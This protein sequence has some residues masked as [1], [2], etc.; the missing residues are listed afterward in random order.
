MKK[1]IIKCI[2]P[3]NGDGEKDSIDIYNKTR[4][5]KDLL[6]QF[7][8]NLAAAPKKVKIDPLKG[9][10]NEFVG[11]IKDIDFLFID[12]DHSIESCK[13][14]FENFEKDLK[15]GGFLAFHDYYK[16]REDLGPTWVIQNLV[17]KNIQYTHYMNYDS[18]CV[19]I[20]KSIVE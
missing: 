20:K 7:K 1:G 10:S 2:D 8:E 17:E 9:Y 18:L 11:I 5:E 15:P 19:F 3:F 12:G 16:E 13:F 14:D 6:L 4:G